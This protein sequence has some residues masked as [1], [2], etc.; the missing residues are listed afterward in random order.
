MPNNHKIDWA[1]VIEEIR[2]TGV[3]PWDLSIALDVHYETVRAWQAGRSEP[4]YSVAMTI[5]ELRDAHQS[6]D[7]AEARCV[8]VLSKYAQVFGLSVFCRICKAAVLC[9]LRYRE[10]RRIV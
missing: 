10:G 1:E 4:R 7:Q 9:Y 3:T 2:K 5:L 8:S 6:A